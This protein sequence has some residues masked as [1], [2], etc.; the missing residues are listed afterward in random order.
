MGNTISKEDIIKTVK[1]LE[2]YV[3]LRLDS[4]KSLPSATIDTTLNLPPGS[5]EH[6]LDASL[7]DLEVAAPL[8]E[9]VP[10]SAYLG[11]TTVPVAT[12]P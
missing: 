4:A 5:E 6:Y 9:G 10:I 1:K 12:Q 2:T 7:G 8:D 3:E 11:A